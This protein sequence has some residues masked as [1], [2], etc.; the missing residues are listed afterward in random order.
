MNRSGADAPE[1]QR[2]RMRTNKDAAIDKILMKAVED[3]EAALGY[4]PLRPVYD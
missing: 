3:A 1:Q 2:V 4:P